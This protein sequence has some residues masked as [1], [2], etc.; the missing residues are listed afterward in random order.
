[1]LSGHH[2]QVQAMLVSLPIVL[3]AGCASTPTEPP[4]RITS[5]AQLASPELRAK[6]ASVYWRRNS[7]PDMRR[8]N[9]KRVAVT[10]F[11]VE[12]ITSKIEGNAR[13]DI[14]Y[15]QYLFDLLPQEL[16]AL[17]VREVEQQKVEVLPIAAVT[18]SRAYMRF[19]TVASKGYR[20]PMEGVYLA[21]SD[22]GRVKQIDIYSAPGL[23]VLKGAGGADMESVEADLLK[24]VGADVALR[25][26]LRLGCFA[27]HATIE[28][29]STVWVLS[30]D[31]AGNLSQEM[32]LA[33]DIRIVEAEK[34]TLV[35]VWVPKYRAAIEEMFPPLIAMAFL[36][37]ESA[38][39][40]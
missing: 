4:P 38:L 36:S 17:F 8:Y 15:S 28:R 40:P 34:G 20:P 31:V 27:G 19:D 37:R 11:A 18:K 1:M 25:V 7:V 24:E 33:S 21:P 32:T 23:N 12:F 14:A 22:T 2:R 5:A 3:L 13:K 6:Y 39:T 10:E 9:Y 29:G 26:R 30:R 35:D 16:Y